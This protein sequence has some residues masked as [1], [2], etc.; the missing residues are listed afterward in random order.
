MLLDS[1]ISY[2]KG[3]YIAMKKR[4]LVFGLV[5]LMLA[6]GVGTV[7]AGGAKNGTTVFF[8]TLQSSTGDYVYCEGYFKTTGSGIVHE[9]R[10]NPECVPYA[11]T[12]PSPSLHL[13]FKPAEKFDSPDCDADEIVYWS[14]LWTMNTTT[15]QDVPGADD[16]ADL[17]DFLGEAG[18]DFW[19]VCIY[20]W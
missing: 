6:L 16:E 18:V 19:Q 12:I 20:E 17:E 4:V 9:W 5:F 13:V 8:N 11:P 1:S 2:S 10:D 3:R 14:G 15:Y 7:L